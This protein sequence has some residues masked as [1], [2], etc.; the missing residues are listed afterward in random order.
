MLKLPYQVTMYLYV[1]TRFC[2]LSMP[3][4]F[5]NHGIF[6]TIEFPRSWDSL[7]WCEVSLLMARRQKAINTLKCSQFIFLQQHN[8]LIRKKKHRIMPI[9]QYKLM[10]RKFECR[11]C[12][13]HPKY[14]LLFVCKKCD[15]ILCQVC[16]ACIEC[17]KG[18]FIKLSLKMPV[19]S[20]SVSHL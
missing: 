14:T 12:K 17:E 13:I 19:L 1:F 6:H 18:W 16:V 7:F 4:K 11:R 20:L 15:M 9:C 2:C 8:V 3:W 10:K 5:P